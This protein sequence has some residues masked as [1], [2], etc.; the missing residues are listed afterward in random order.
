[1]K[2]KLVIGMALICSFQIAFA[3]ATARPEVVR[4]AI[5]TEV[6]RAKAAGEIKASD[7][8]HDAKLGSTLA[9]IAG[10]S[11]GELRSA[12]SRTIQVQETNGSKNVSLREI[13]SLL[14][15]ADEVSRTQGSP[16]AMERAIKISSAFLSLANRDP[17]NSGVVMT[18]QQKLELAAF[19]KQLSLIPEILTKMDAADMDAHIKVMEKAVEKRATPTMNGEQAFAVALKEGRSQEDYLQKL[20]ELTGCVR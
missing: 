14:V 13:G 8:T 2:T 5:E 7:A 1:M 19:N 6:A 16:P 9:R 11:E 3:A 4:K 20:N 10:T 18:E 17:R 12:L 15:K